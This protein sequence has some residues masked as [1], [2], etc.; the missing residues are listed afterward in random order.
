MDVTDFYM[1]S[2]ETIVEH[3]LTNPARLQLSYTHGHLL[4]EIVSTCYFTGPSTTRSIVKLVPSKSLAVVME[5]GVPRHDTILRCLQTISSMAYAVANDSGVR[6]LLQVDCPAELLPV[7][8]TKQK[9]KAALMQIRDVVTNNG[10]YCGYHLI[11]SMVPSAA[12]EFVPVGDATDLLLGELRTNHVIESKPSLLRT[13]SAVC[14]RFSY[15]NGTWFKATEGGGW[16]VCQDAPLQI[17]REMEV[18]KELGT[19]RLKDAWDAAFDCEDADGKMLY[20][21][22]SRQIL[23]ITHQ[24]MTNAAMSILLNRP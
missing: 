22:C 15:V 16:R 1:I 8:K 17:T 20:G 21:T 7:P 23:N 18:I 14:L 24:D 10:I 11:S 19:I 9:Q 12:P 4:D 5:G 3:I 2:K 6:K 13:V